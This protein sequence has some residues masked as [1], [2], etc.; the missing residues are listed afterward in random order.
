VTSYDELIRHYPCDKAIKVAEGNNGLTA[1]EC[2]SLRPEYFGP[3][4]RHTFH[5]VVL[6]ECH[7]IKNR[8]SRSESDHHR[9]LN[10][11]DTLTMLQSHK[12]ASSSW[13]NTDGC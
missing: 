4:L 5:R 11:T 8:N 13:P 6:D 9:H 12:H 1:E 7:I 10:G 3:L 2:K